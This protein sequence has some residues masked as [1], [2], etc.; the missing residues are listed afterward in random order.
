M[1]KIKIE[2]KSVIESTEKIVE[3]KKTMSEKLTKINELIK[4]YSIEDAKA[5]IEIG[6]LTIER[7]PKLEKLVEAEL[8]EFE[9]ISSVDK[10][11]DGI[12]ANIS[13]QV[14]EIQKKQN[15]DLEKFKSEYSNKIEELNKT[16]DAK[17]KEALD[18]WEKKLKELT[19]EEEKV[20]EK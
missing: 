19:T 18:N 12:N 7:R 4:E 1:R 16:I 14:E 10:D 17:E 15:E 6:K 3:I 13:N 20:E 9:S 11:E 2:D 5:N 8:K